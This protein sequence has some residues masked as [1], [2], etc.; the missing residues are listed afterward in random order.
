MLPVAEAL[1][2]ITAGVTPLEAETVPL[3]D[4]AG[5]VLAADVVSAL[6]QPPFRSSAMDG[7]AVRSSDVQTLPARLKLVGESGAGHP[8]GGEVGPGETVRIFTGAPVPSGADLIVIQENV[9]PLGPIAEVRELSE[10]D[11]LRPEGFDFT[12]GQALLRAGRRLTARD[13][14]LAAQ[15]NVTALAVTRRPLVAILA[16]GDELV[17]PGEIP[18][19]G[20]I[21]SSIPAGLAALIRNAGAEPRLLGIARDTMASLAE[22]LGR[23]G[24]ADILVTIGGASVGEHDLVR[25]ALE[26]AGFTIAFHN[27]AMR[28]GK[29]L[30]FGV[31]GPCRVLGLPGNPVSAMVTGLIFLKPLIAALLGESALERHMTAPLAAALPA[32]GPRQAYM[33]GR[34]I[35][36]GAV[37]AFASQDSSLISRLAAADCLIIRPPHA[38]AAA[39][40]E[41]VPILPLDA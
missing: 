15:A 39:S 28:P 33:R 30:M 22:K 11:F 1:A 26:E 7:Y 31:R 34:I 21:V 38:P 36:S 40:G 4:A 41:P 19:A 2:R 16:S 8:F 9:T 20:Q 29:P 35:A 10:E 24:Q 6:T 17:E 23:A 5:R 25:H 14:M 18:G 12:A 32:N 13:V 27:V 37:E 3:A